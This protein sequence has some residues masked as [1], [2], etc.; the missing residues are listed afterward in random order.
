MLHRAGNA[1]TVAHTI[2]TLCLASSLEF[3]ELRAWGSFRGVA[4]RK[5]FMRRR[6]GLAVRK[7][8]PLSIIAQ[9]SAVVYE[10]DKST[11]ASQKSMFRNIRA[12]VTLSGEKG[13]SGHVGREILRWGALWA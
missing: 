2:W 3:I 10:V 4:G 11:P 7:V 9:D 5:R 13:L 12:V 6:V 1:T 8:P